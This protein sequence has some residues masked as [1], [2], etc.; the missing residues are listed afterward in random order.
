MVRTQQKK[1]DSM[2]I[3][4]VQSNVV[5]GF[6]Y[7]ID[8]GKAVVTSKNYFRPERCVSL[9]QYQDEL[10]SDFFDLNDESIYESFKKDI[11]QNY[12]SN[13]IVSMSKFPST[14]LKLSL[15]HETTTLGKEIKNIKQASVAGSNS[16][17]IYL[18]DTLNYLFGEGDLKIKTKK[19]IESLKKLK[20]ID[21]ETP[22]ISLSNNI[23]GDLVKP[24]FKKRGRP[25]KIHTD[26][27]DQKAEKHEKVDKAM[28]PLK[29][30]GRPPLKS[31]VLFNVYDPLNDTTL[32]AVNADVS[33]VAESNY[34]ED[35]S[36][37]NVSADIKTEEPKKS[38]LGRKKIKK[39]KIFSAF[40]ET[41]K[42]LNGYLAED[43]VFHSADSL[44]LS[45]SFI[46]NDSVKSK[47]MPNKLSKKEHV[48]KSLK[49][50]IQAA[51]LAR[52]RFQNSGNQS[53][54]NFN[55]DLVCL[56]QSIIADFEQF[57][58][59]TDLDLPL[60]GQAPVTDCEAH[61]A[62]RIQ[63][64]QIE[65]IQTYPK[66]AVKM[67]REYG[68]LGLDFIKS[69]ETPDVVISRLFSDDICQTIDASTLRSDSAASFE[70][71]DPTDFNVRSD[72]DYV[73]A[74]AL[75]DVAA[76]VISKKGPYVKYNHLLEFVAITL[77]DDKSN[78]DD[79]LNKLSTEIVPEGFLKM[80][81]DQKQKFLLG[82][83]HIFVALM[84]YNGENMQ[85]KQ[86]LTSDGAYDSVISLNS[87]TTGS[88]Y[89]SSKENF[90]H[91]KDS[92]LFALDKGKMHSVIP[93]DNANILKKLALKDFNA[94]TSEELRMEAR[95][96]ELKEETEK[97]GIAL[98]PEKISKLIQ[99]VA[100]EHAAQTDFDN[101]SSKLKKGRKIRKNYVLPPE[102]RINSLHYKQEH[103][104]YKAAKDYLLNPGKTSLREVC[105]R[106]KISV[107]T[108]ITYMDAGRVARMLVTG[109]YSGSTVIRDSSF[110]NRGTS[111]FPD[112]IKTLYLQKTYEKI[113]EAKKKAIQTSGST[114]D[115]LVFRL[116][117]AKQE[118]IK[119]QSLE[120]MVFSP[121]MNLDNDSPGISSILKNQSVDVEVSSQQT[122]SKEQLNYIQIPADMQQQFCA[123]I[124]YAKNP[125]EITSALLNSVFNLFNCQD[126][127]TNDLLQHIDIEKISTDCIEAMKN[128]VQGIVDSNF[129]FDNFLE[130][131]FKKKKGR[132]GSRKVSEKSTPVEL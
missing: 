51:I 5:K 71:K 67:K 98:T 124:L 9:C 28:K 1:S 22:D 6:S 63:F 19:I 108:L 31:N 120:S 107:P 25:P 106:H 3:L 42:P 70:A 73:V 123:A 91:S 130:G 14:S 27:E 66:N 7:M 35:A 78:S 86:I 2:N 114:D 119:K 85:K 12:L 79:V 96:E 95:L 46:K 132:G 13:S 52:L 62:G 93:D 102:P 127:E 49:K 24:T 121:S 44:Q 37:I 36:M 101:D 30:R 104:K 21:V 97:L 99:Q 126:K 87:T 23:Y 112:E 39:S 116:A 109:K 58:T 32:T 16:N 15:K 11:S 26:I 65:T 111:S 103:K 17:T 110:N 74:S 125:C 43:S 131:T 45:K 64:G 80:N 81:Q 92:I 68:S 29:K 115:D 83:K 47:D 60:A 88:V 129:D 69:V 33:T 18:S 118:L 72:S 38:H 20:K 84:K 89:N 41:Y 4:E 61:G 90:N 77:S 40:A 34:S 56:Q 76:S 100:E 75:N 10:D 8:N 59:L 53:S 54:K 94:K 50:Q 117:L 105:Q 113:L 82:I 122:E 55:K 48:I 57:E 128:S